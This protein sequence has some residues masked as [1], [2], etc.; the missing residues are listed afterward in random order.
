M[1]KHGAEVRRTTKVGQQGRK[2]RASAVSH[3]AALFFSGVGSG[4][5]RAKQL[6]P[7][8]DSPHATVLLTQ[9]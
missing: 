2:D 1:A 9:Q 7:N 8:P 3:N 5:Y 6:S 4:R